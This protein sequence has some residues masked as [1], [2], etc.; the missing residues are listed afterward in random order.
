M[1][2]TWRRDTWHV[3][4]RTGVI[5]WGTLNT[6]ASLFQLS[7]TRVERQ[8]ITS[9]IESSLL[10]LLFCHTQSLFPLSLLSHSSLFCLTLFIRFYYSFFPYHLLTLGTDSKLQQSKEKRQTKFICKQHCCVKWLLCPSIVEFTLFN[11]N[12]W[13]QYYNDNKMM[14]SPGQ[15]KSWISNGNCDRLPAPDL[16]KHSNK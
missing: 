13:N 7:L 8:E 4:H 15:C 14:T 2:P 12:P 5:F 10:S 9:G 1:T 16:E 11:S 6:S 3:T